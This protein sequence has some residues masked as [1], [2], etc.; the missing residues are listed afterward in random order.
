MSKRK[1]GRASSSEKGAT[2]P[3]AASAP[4]APSKIPFR[5]VLPFA[6]AIFIGA[7]LLFAIQPLIARYVLPWFGGGPGIWATCML[8]FQ[9]LLLAGYLYA[10]LSTRFLSTRWQ[11]MLHLLLLAGSLLVIPVIPSAQWKP[12]AAD[13]P[14]WRI[15]LLLGA[16]IGLPYFT[17]S[18]TS[19]LLQAWFVKVRPGVSPYRLFALSNLGSLLAL[20]AYPLV[21]E[22]LLTRQQQAWIWSAG[23]VLF[24]LTCVACALHIWLSRLIEPE[25]II[26]EKD[27]HGPTPARSVLLWLA[28]PFAASVLLLATTNTITEDVAATPLFW[29]IPLSLYLLTFI[30]A[31]DSPRW[32]P[33]RVVLCVLPLCAWWIF[34]IKYV[35]FIRPQESLLSFCLEYVTLNA[36][37]PALLEQFCAYLVGMFAVCLFCHGELAALR[38]S[39]SRLTGYY[40]YIALGGALGGVFVALA[41]PKLFTQLHELG[42]GILLA[43]ILSFVCVRISS[44]PRLEWVAAAFVAAALVLMPGYP[45]LARYAQQY[46]KVVD[47]SRNFYGTLLVAQ[48]ESDLGPMRMLYHGT[49]HHGFQLLDPSRRTQPTLYYQRGSGVGDTM[50]LYPATGNRKIGLVGLGVGT[51]AAYGKPGDTFRFYEI[52]PDIERIARQHFTFL[53]DSPSHIEIVLGDAR[54][55]LD[56]ESSQQFDILVLDA[57]S[58]DAIP[59]HLLTAEAF[60]I[61]ARHLKPGGVIAAH[62]SNRSVVLGPVLIR[63]AT[64]LHMSAAASSSSD[65]WWLMMTHNQAFLNDP[66]VRRRMQIAAVK[67]PAPLWTDDHINLLEAIRWVPTAPAAAQ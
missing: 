12:T 17:L 60:D 26:A 51:L 66:R 34:R 30:I 18:A 62:F 15:L 54:L 47:R 25:A 50:E 36:V 38:P 10:H 27:D 33:R 46:L 20:L 29:V 58:G 63:Q 16:T 37:P 55:T 9:M 5:A 41:A 35:L 23:L 22:P 28:L 6:A 2:R 13:D 4:V 64:R 40:L 32:Y 48:I 8:F 43:A 44:T 59:T 52:N 49:T 61:Y 39:P 19:P 65:S 7:L 3:P 14:S 56:R 11:I 53:A 67:T 21:L 1:Q 57:F 45:L 24:A 42:I 31:F